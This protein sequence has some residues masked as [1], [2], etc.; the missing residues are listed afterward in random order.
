MARITVRV[1]PR[2]H[3]SEAAGRVGN[4]WKLRIAAPPVDGKANQE[5]IRLLADLAGVPRG[6]VRIV[7]GE[8]ARTKLIEIDGIE[9]AEL[10][11]RLSG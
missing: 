2:A 11:R 4:A 3:R 8:T 1:Q 6:S 10:E 5:C 7:R 9:Q